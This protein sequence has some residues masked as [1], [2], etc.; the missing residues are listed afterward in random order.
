MPCLMKLTAPPLAI[1]DYTVVVSIIRNDFVYDAW[2]HIQMICYTST[3]IGGII[4]WEMLK[5]TC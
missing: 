4:A 3:R 1:K 5:V 2:C